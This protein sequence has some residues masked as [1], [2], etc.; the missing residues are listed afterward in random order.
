MQCDA[1]Y[2]CL[3]GVVPDRCGCCQVLIFIIIMFRGPRNKVGVVPDKFLGPPL[4]KMGVVPDRCG[5]CQVL[6]FIIMVFRAP[7]NKM[8]VVPGSN[9][10]T[11]NIPDA[12][13]LSRV[14]VLPNVMMPDRCRCCQIL[15][16]II[17]IETRSLGGPL[18]SQLLLVTNPDFFILTTITLG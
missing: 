6:I 2:Q 17:I 3:A 13:M 14:I 12:T 18:G 1:L 8:E 10:P 5:C 15:I 4:N 7:L 11:P 9:N 16:F